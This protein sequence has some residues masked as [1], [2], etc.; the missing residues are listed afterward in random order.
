MCLDKF[1]KGQLNFEISQDDFRNFIK[2]SKNENIEVVYDDTKYKC[3]NCGKQ[4]KE[5]TVFEHHLDFHFLSNEE[6]K[7]IMNQSFGKF[8]DSKKFQNYSVN[9]MLLEREVN[10]KK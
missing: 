7:K 2:H 3:L 6:K 4:F 9:F 1:I 8:I 5:K 10:R